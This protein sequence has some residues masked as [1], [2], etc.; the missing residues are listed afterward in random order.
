MTLA[1]DSQNLPGDVHDAAVIFDGFD[2]RGHTST[3][4]CAVRVSQYHTVYSAS[5]RTTTYNIIHWHKIYNPVRQFRFRVTHDF[6]VHSRYPT[7]NSVSRIYSEITV[8]V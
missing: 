8:S 3:R 7:V 2:I 4:L 5:L 6:L 1:P